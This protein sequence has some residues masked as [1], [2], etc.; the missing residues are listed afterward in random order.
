MLGH[1]TPRASLDPTFYAW[2]S[3]RFHYYTSFGYLS[4]FSY[5][6]LRYFM[7]LSADGYFILFLRIRIAMYTVLLLI[8]EKSKKFYCPLGSVKG[9]TTDF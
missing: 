7:V 6:I 4:Y 3:I 1:Y 5:T 2:G 8:L 9:T